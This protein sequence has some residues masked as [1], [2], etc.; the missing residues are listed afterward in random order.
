MSDART[1]SS[2]AE[3]HTTST[4]APC[5]YAINWLTVRSEIELPE[6][7][8][9]GDWDAGPEVTVRVGEI[10]DI[11]RNGKPRKHW[12]SVLDDQ[13]IFVIPG[14]GGYCIDDGERITVSPEPK[15]EMSNVRT[16]LLGA[17]FAALLH[18]R[19]ALLLHIS[20]V[21]T[22]EG[23]IAFTGPSGAGKSTMAARLH[24]EHGWPIVCDDSA[25]VK[26]VDG[27]PMIYSG[28]RRLR[29]WK[30]AIERLDVDA[31]GAER[32]RIF[33]DK[34]QLTMKDRFVAQPVT[35]TRL[36]TIGDVSGERTQSGL[37][38]VA[39]ILRAVH[40]PELLTKQGKEMTF[41]Q[42]ILLAQALS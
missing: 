28:V 36:D 40:R 24:L 39:T 1:G 15:S 32:D 35:L 9:P 29:L 16:F 22:P 30:D 5:L 12:L 37:D 4:R 33:R 8:L 42:V 2:P 14:V 17:A 10:P 13:T 18:Q 7:A 3:K 38:K 26:V 20:A 21:E 6:A 34:Y 23:A 41:Q 19:G 31:K 25:V 11:L 27:Q